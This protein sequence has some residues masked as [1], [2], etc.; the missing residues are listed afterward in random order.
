MK[1]IFV[2]GALS[3]IAQET[4]RCFAAEGAAFFLAAR[5]GE[6]LAIS[7]AD[8]KTRG[9][10]SVTVLAADFDVLESHAEIVRKAEAELGGI[11]IA[12]IA[13]GFLPDQTA[14]EQDFDLTLKAIHTNFI[15]VV[16][17][18]MQLTPLFENQRGGTMA[19]IGSVAGDR[20]RPKNYVYGTS[21]GALA[22]FLQGLRARLS[23]S[24][25]N[26]LTVKPGFVDTPMTAGH[27]KNI[28]FADAPSVGCAIHR[29]ILARKDILY[30]PGF[31][32][33]IL[34]VIQCIPEGLFKKL[35]L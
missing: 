27:A 26:V 12:L 4:A 22:L 18:V 3:A 35:K 31:W 19:V 2:A 1:K 23:R 33:W 32:R 16:S 29:A 20:G 34:F 25:V 5:D 15:S 21:K 10:S 17:L 30:V 8:L 13:Y 9:A 6:K 11:E 28:L 7:G 24:G 14:C